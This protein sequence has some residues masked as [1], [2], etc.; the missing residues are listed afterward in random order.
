MYFRILISI[1]V[2][3]FLI[4]HG[5]ALGQLNIDACDGYFGEGLTLTIHGNGFGSNYDPGPILFEDFDNGSHGE[6]IG[7]NGGS[8]WILDDDTGS[9]QL[10][11]YSSSQTRHSNSTL[12]CFLSFGP[13][14]I[15]YQNICSLSFQDP[16]L[17][18]VYFSGW[19]F[20]TQTDS[21]EFPDYFNVF[22]HGPYS[23]NGLGKY[24]IR[25]QDGIRWGQISSRSCLLGQPSETV[26]GPS[27]PGFESWHRLEIWRGFGPDGTSENF[28]VSIDG[29][30]PI[31]LNRTTEECQLGEISLFNYFMDPDEIAAMDFFLDDIYIHNSR[32]RIEIGN[33][34]DFQSCTHREVQVTSSW[35][36]N[37]ITFTAKQ[38]S[39]SFEEPVYVFVV[40]DEGEASPGFQISWVEG[41]LSPPGPP[42]TPENLNVE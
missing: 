15:G 29:A 14:L 26:N 10:P 8:S 38:G 9:S 42:N 31:L 3:I 21:Q 7:S 4:P 28:T 23:G 13:R 41:D 6:I 5:I 2:G 35:D 32:A 40:N 34:Q 22:G 11:Q 18:E 30:N 1:F 24:N 27:F 20:S 17:N 37:Q 39:F 16:R 33:A 25:F 12:S 36:A 19:L